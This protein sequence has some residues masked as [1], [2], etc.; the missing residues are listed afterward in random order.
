MIG[1]SRAGK[2]YEPVA[3]KLSFLPTGSIV[4]PVA[5]CSWKA[6]AYRLDSFCARHS[7][8][9]SSS[10]S[11]RRPQRT[12]LVTVKYYAV[13]HVPIGLAVRPFHV[14]VDRDRHH[15]DDLAHRI[16]PRRSESPVGRAARLLGSDG[17]CALQRQAV[18]EIGGRA[19]RR[20]AE[21]CCQRAATVIDLARPA[22]AP[23]TLGQ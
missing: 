3:T 18:D 15:P 21:R 7:S 11:P 10:G 14:A 6:C 20:G 4:V 12:P 2:G 5:R 17:G 22:R 19:S 1:V 13:D 8:A 23:Q 16:R 9:R